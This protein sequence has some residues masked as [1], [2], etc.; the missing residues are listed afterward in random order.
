MTP[1]WIE[2]GINLTHRRFDADR[3]AVIEAARQ[4]G[5][6]QMVLTGTDAPESARALALAQRFP[7]RLF[8]TAGVHPHDASRWGP[9][10]A[11]EIHRLL[12]APEVVAVGECGLDYNRDFSP[13]PQQRAAFGAQL[14][15]ARAVQKPLFLHCRDAEADFFELLRPYAPTA[16]GPGA[17]MHCFTGDAQTLQ[18]A[19]DLGCFI[20]ITGWIRDER[21]GQELYALLPQIPLDRLLLETDA[22]FLLPRDLR[23]R[24]K[25]GRNHPA[26]LPHIGVAVARRLG[27]SIAEVAAATTA[28]ARRLFRLPTP[29]EPT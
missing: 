7:G 5:V 11:A 14:E 1:E 22:P 21:R 17:V 2:I 15:L 16:G 27:L 10:E 24:P 23:P 12:G 4:A 20:G 25:D 26:F 9:A 18:T 28:N 8:S 13:R 19:L 6:V 29:P 3:D